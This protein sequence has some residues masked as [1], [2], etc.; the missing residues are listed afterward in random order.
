MSSHDDLA[1]ALDEVR[2]A[3]SKAARECH[4]GQPLRS[5]QIYAWTLQH[6]GAG[7]F[8]SSRYGLGEYRGRVLAESAAGTLDRSS[9]IARCQATTA[10]LLSL[11]DE[12]RGPR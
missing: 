2:A 10:S 4:L 11:R 5:A 1:A 12:L 7:N 8:E 3:A 6:L 9:L